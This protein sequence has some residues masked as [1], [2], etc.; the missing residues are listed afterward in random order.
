MCTGSDVDGSLT[1]DGSVAL[2]GRCA[3]N[4]E[5]PSSAL[6]NNLQSK[7]MGGQEGMGHVFSH[8]PILFDA[9]GSNAVTGDYLF[10][11]Y[12]PSGNRNGMFG[13]LRVE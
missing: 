1:T 8:W 5:V 2:A 4:A 10:R 13:I 7:Y 3:P 11:D 12:M 9:G 6:G